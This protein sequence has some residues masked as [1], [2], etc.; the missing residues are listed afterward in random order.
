MTDHPPTLV[1]LAARLDAACIC[2]EE[3]ARIECPYCSAVEDAP[4]ALVMVVVAIRTLAADW[5]KLASRY[6][7][8]PE[9]G[10]KSE[11]LFECARRL[12]GLLGDK[13]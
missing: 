11:V 1:D 13:Q 9:S 4:G 6:Y 10:D 3:S 8:R 7:D 12:R 5:D 2:G